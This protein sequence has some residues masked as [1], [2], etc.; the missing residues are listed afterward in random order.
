MLMTTPALTVR[1]I[2]EIA[3]MSVGSSH[4][5]FSESKSRLCYAIT[6]TKQLI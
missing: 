5:I 3:R 2:A 4:A 6:K 1:E